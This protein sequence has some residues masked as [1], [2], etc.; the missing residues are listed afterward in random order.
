LRRGGESGG[1]NEQNGRFRVVQNFILF[2][3]CSVIFEFSAVFGLEGKVFEFGRRYLIFG[4]TFSRSCLFKV[5][6][7]GGGCLPGGFGIGVGKSYS[8]HPL[9]EVNL[10]R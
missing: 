4:A 3:F 10:M 1:L 8:G 5:N 6:R 9:K 7:E 2:E